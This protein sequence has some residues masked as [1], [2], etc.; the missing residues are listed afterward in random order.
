MPLPPLSASLSPAVADGG[1]TPKQMRDR[2][3]YWSDPIKAR[4]ARKARYWK[5]PEKSRASCREQKRAEYHADPDKA[6]AAKRDQYARAPEVFVERTRQWR[7][8]NPEK[9]KAIEARRDKE[10]LADAALVRRYGL[11]REQWAQMK[12]AQDNRCAICVE[13][14]G[15][16]KGIH[17]DHCHQTGRVRQLLCTHCNTM[18]GRAKDNPELLRRGAAYLEEWSAN[19]AEEA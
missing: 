5:H 1:L 3:R 14:F 17:V 19:H 6:R 12:T 18:L 4:A 2:Q 11:S 10:R 9:A 13:E 7:A 15:V 16:R 8:G